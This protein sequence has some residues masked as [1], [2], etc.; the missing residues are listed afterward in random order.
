MIDFEA[1]FGKLSRLL[2]IFHLYRIIFLFH[3]NGHLSY[4]AKVKPPRLNGQRVGVYSTRSPHRPNSLGLTLAKLDKIQ[5]LKSFWIRDFVVWD[6]KFS[7]LWESVREH[8]L[9]YFRLSSAFMFC[10][11]SCCFC[12]FLGDTLHLSDIDMIAG[13][14]VLDVKPYIP[15]Y[16]SPN[17]R[18]VFDSQQS[19]SDTDLTAAPENKQTSDFNCDAESKLDDDDED[20]DVILH[21]VGKSDT[22]VSLTASLTEAAPVFLPKETLSLLKEV[23]S[24]MNKEDSSSSEC[25]TKCR[26]SGRVNNE[27]PEPIT[28]WPC[29][30]VDSSTTIADW[31]REPPVSSLDVRFTP[32]AQKQ[33]EEFLPALVGGETAGNSRY[34]D[35][36]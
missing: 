18:T 6:G 36:P 22:D 3:K 16:D 2:I 23:E 9:N 13:T 25:E 1:D 12:C 8:G 26:V 27:A 7:A 17:S 14:P 28:D 10:C 4:K 19:Q 31:I 33:L 35:P 20:E 5:G 11:N 30:G 29:Y 15:E 21:P 32:H 24:F 34:T